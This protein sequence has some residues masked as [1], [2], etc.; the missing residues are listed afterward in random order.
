M[1]YCIFTIATL[2]FVIASPLVALQIF[3]DP[4][5][6]DDRNSLQSAQDTVGA[7]KT[8]THALA[9]A[10]AVTDT[11]PH[12]IEL[13]PGKYSPSTGQTFPLEISESKIHL[14]A[15]EDN[16]ATVFDA[17]GRSN[18][19]NFP[20]PI[21]EITIRGID[22]YN[23]RADKGGFASCNTCSLRV[24]E[25]RFFNNSASSSGHVIFSK[26]GRI[27]L[28]NNIFRNNGSGHDTLG[29]IH[30]Q[31]KFPDASNQD[32]I[33]EIRNNIFYRNRS[34]DIWTSS[35][36]LRVS[37][38]IFIA[39]GSSALR[40]GSLD[41]RPFLDH[42]IFWQTDV[43][44]VSPAIDNKSEPDSIDIA[45]AVRDTASFSAEAFTLSPSL[46][47]VPNIKPLTFRSDSLS[48]KDLSIR[49]PTAVTGF[50]DTLIK[51][52][53]TH[54]YLINV[55]GYPSA[56]E[57][58]PITFPEGLDT[59]A[60]RGQP[61]LFLW[62][63]TPND[64]GVH[65][66]AMEIT[67]SY[68]LVDTLS[69]RLN[70][71][72]A[73]DFPDTSSFRAIQN[74]QGR[75]IGMFRETYSH[76]VPHTA[77]ERY[78]FDID[79]WGKKD[80]YQF[81]PL[82]LPNTAFG[83][84]ITQNGL[85]DWTPTAEDT[86]R[87]QIQVA[88]TTPSGIVDTLSFNIFVFEDH[89]FPDTSSSDVL[90]SLSLL[91][92]TTNGIAQLN[93]IS[94][95][96]SATQSAVGNLY[97]NPVLLDT[98]YNRYEL[99]VG[100][101]PA[102]NAGPGEVS[103]YDKNETRNDMGYW[104][105]PQNS[106]LPNPII[107]SEILLTTKP[108]SLLVE[109][110]T[111]VYDPVQANGNPFTFVDLLSL[112]PGSD[113]PATI[114][115]SNPFGTAPPIQW[116]P[117]I[118]DTGKYILGLK[119]YA[120]DGSFGRHYFPIRVRPLNEI[121]Y[122]LTK[123]DTS[124]KEDTPYNFAIR[125]NDIDGDNILYRL[126]NG[127]QNL[128]IDI[129][130]GVV[131]WLPT[132]EQVGSH[133]ITVRIEDSRGATSDYSWSVSVQPSNDAPVIISQPDT[134][135]QEDVPF[136]YNLLVSDPDP[137]DVFFPTLI[138]GPLGV[139]ID[140]IGSLIWT[141][142]QS[143]IGRHQIEIMV[144]DQ[145][146][147]EA[148]QTFSVLVTETNDAPQFATIKDSTVKEDI[149]YEIALVA[150]DQDDENLIYTLNNGPERMVLKNLKTIS[151]LPDVI[152][153]GSHQV[154][155]SVMDPSGL[156]D[157]LNYQLHV[158]PANDPPLITS[159]TPVDSIILSAEETLLF[160]VN[161]EDEENDI[162]EYSWLR[163]GE[164]I[165]NA[166][167]NSLAFAPT[168]NQ[169]DSIAVEI[170]DAQ[171][172][173]RFTWNIDLRSMPRLSL[174]STEIDFARVTLGDTLQQTIAITNVG[175]L[176][177]ELDSLQLS[178]PVFDASLSN[179]SINPGDK[180]DLNLRFGPLDRGSK[181]DTVR[182][183]SNDPDNQVLEVIAKG[184]GYIGTTLN[185]DLS[186]TIGDQKARA[187]SLSGGQTFGLNVYAYDAVDLQSFRVTLGFDPSLLHFD[188]FNSVSDSE[189]NIL[190]QNGR[191]PTYKTEYDEG[192][193]SVIFRGN[194][195]T[196]G[197]SGDGL[198]GVV[199][200]TVDSLVS[201]GTTTIS[202]TQGLITSDQIA[203]A[204]TVG[205]IPS[206]VI[207]LRPKLQGDFDFDLDV[208]F[209]DFFIF[210]DSFG[211]EDFNPLTDLN[212]DGEVSFDDFF[213]FSDAFGRATTIAKTSTY[214]IHPEKFK[215]NV[216][217]I[218]PDRLSI[219]PSW[220]GEEPTKGFV[221]GLEFNPNVLRF[222][223]YIGRNPSPPLMLILDS[224]PGQVTIAVGA[225]SNQPP[226]EQ[227]GNIEFVRLSN[228]KTILNPVLAAHYNGDTNA[229]YHEIPD[230]IE[231]NALPTSFT[232]YPAHPNPFN[233]E[234]TIELYAPRKTDIHLTIYDLLGQTVRTLIKGEM[235]PG[236]HQIIWNGRNNHG[237]QVASGTY[238]LV[239]EADNLRHLQKLLLL[240]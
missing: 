143:Q 89:A 179:L 87:H 230:P 47:I 100:S 240:K 124:A 115:P 46:K 107:G 236:Y 238:F 180:S 130:S 98:T 200:F 67:D 188:G 168:Q 52:G 152:D 102:I 54:Q 70:V 17:E 34:A 7:Y 126:T 38:N 134:L 42:N 144:R 147:S 220:T 148:S 6:G 58:K 53:Q 129:N 190:S 191:L 153:V 141:P 104:G 63:P 140:S 5:N 150:T 65:T 112:S 221:V 92:D 178:N 123:P 154:N 64:V 229:T 165:P 31:N 205:F 120:A 199:N 44:Y 43:L 208:D 223:K 21:E 186:S 228:S 187:S 194:I 80:S 210:S 224:I 88:I 95:S 77:G 159:K 82:E 113:V 125:A 14:R 96:F 167:K 13:L 239:M 139:S 37:G 18:F 23:G 49:M 73:S 62:T 45:L 22:F 177:L 94:P 158:A 175:D 146:D 237:K 157:T 74:S 93:S 197:V 75:F 156:S 81:N 219:A 24:I 232:L 12:V 136:Q 235:L 39:P 155:V 8:I 84:S 163:N 56:Y 116:T 226:L 218:A 209:D 2:F 234:T 60:V 133:D 59:I 76:E 90:V 4:I 231:I 36:H 145:N 68:G 135:A 97:A 122:S 202:M 20:K 127:P 160:R 214:T 101:S 212:G 225:S 132:Q 128:S 50:P 51:V 161:V 183:V 15:I 171:D 40:N 1:A 11:R 195:A 41:T 149:L 111:F 85:I 213:L 170:T 131:T 198:I 83:N 114:T 203:I 108:D 193:S 33:D 57:F 162:V 137:G 185:F 169:L 99:V 61:R 106:G 121:P 9:V 204:D 164:Y 196:G 118:A 19:F 117:T 105:G 207:S 109:G 173:T 201:R 26:N 211:Q 138:T 3:V 216:A 184:D 166:I 25:N 28:R 48:T 86:G 222:E 79:V 151:W 110:Q 91:P 181:F 172:T 103:F 206:A 78:L 174:S 35:T 227:L 69:Y 233:P 16:G 72:N 30:L 182:F 119:S 29:V 71:F 55:T 192:A 27:R 142:L 176:T 189:V 215:I 217:E 10:H 66:I 32:E